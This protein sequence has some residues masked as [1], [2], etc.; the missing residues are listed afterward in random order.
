MNEQVLSKVMIRNM[1]TDK[2]VFIQWLQCENVEDMYTEICK[3]AK[4]NGLEQIYGGDY[5]IY[6]WRN[7]KF[8]KYKIF[9]KS[10]DSV[11]YYSKEDVNVPVT[12]EGM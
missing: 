3:I 2:I 1:V 4:N 6:T 10:K 9:G 7:L 11:M 12:M 5:F 8:G